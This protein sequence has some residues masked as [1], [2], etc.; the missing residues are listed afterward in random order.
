[1]VGCCRP[2][3]VSWGFR[4]HLGRQTR[5]VWHEHR[6]FCPGADCDFTAGR[7]L[8][9]LD[10]RRRRSRSWPTSLFRSCVV[11]ESERDIVVLV[12]SEPT[13][14]ILRRSGTVATQSTTP[15]PTPTQI[16]AT[17]PRPS[18]P[19]SNSSCETTTDPFGGTRR[20]QGNR[21]CGCSR[22]GPGRCVGGVAGYATTTRLSA[23]GI[24]A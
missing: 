5:L 7:P 15:T 8:V 1:M 10:H 16:S 21:G 12:G 19:K 14:P 11:R 22:M 20:K 17:T 24:T 18:W 3:L 6:W 4:F 13:S 2:G 23:G 9:H